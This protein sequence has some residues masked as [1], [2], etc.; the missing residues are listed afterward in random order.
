MQNH[1]RKRLA[2]FRGPR[3]GDL[4]MLPAHLS[5]HRVLF[6]VA[7]G[8]RGFGLRPAADLADFLKCAS[9][10]AIQLTSGDPAFLRK[11][12]QPRYVA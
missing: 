12:P 1:C 11:L 8:P 3:D 10:Q 7:I 5:S 2:E 6:A 4:G 9:H